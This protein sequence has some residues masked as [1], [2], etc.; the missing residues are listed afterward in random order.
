MDHDA[1]MPPKAARTLQALFTGG[2]HEQVV[3]VAHEA[4]RRG[5]AAELP[6]DLPAALREALLAAGVQSLHGHQAAARDL[7]AAGE[8][9]V[10]STGT[11]SGKSLCYQLAVLEAFAADPQ[12]RALFLFP[13]K[14]LAQDQA[15]KLNRF[16]VPGVVPAIY[17]GDTPQDQRPL[18]QAHR[19]DPAQQ[20][21]HA[22]R[23]HPARPRALGRVPAPAAV[24]RARRGARLPRRLRQPRRPGRAPPAAPLPRSTA[25]TRAFV[26]TSA[27]I[28]N[29]QALRRAAG[30]RAVRGRRRGPGAASRADGRPLEPAARGP[31]RRRAPERARRGELRDGRVRARRRARDRLR[32]DAQGGG[33][34]LRPRP[35][36]PRGPR[37]ARRGGPGAAVSRRLHAGAA[38]R[39][40]AAPV[41]PRARRRRGDAGARAGHRRRQPGRLAG[42]RLPGHD[43]QPAPAL[44]TGRPVRARLRRAG[45]RPG[46]ARP[47]LH[48]RA[49]PPPGAQR[50]GGDHRPAQPA[51]QRPAPGGGRVRAAA[52][53]RRRGLLRRGGPAAG[54]AA[55]AGRPAAAAQGRPRL[56]QALL[57]RRRASACARRATSSSPSSRPAR[58]RSSAPSSA[59]ASSASATP[60]PSTCTWA[61]AT[62]S[63]TS[64]SRRAPS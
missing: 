16:R 24:R 11:A 40:R 41:R 12:A 21:R 3:T 44:G 33:A 36:P 7:L 9:V 58:A 46:R 35:P 56:G 28:A 50:R 34:R 1:G 23:R 61:G 25:P 37:P 43:H 38:A 5:R 17:D 8:N 49:R 64:T 14:A 54:R 62:S 32:A 47:V 42:H 26:L 60:A 53:G 45:G 48:A 18:L 51:H 59:S 63:S 52:H 4:A 6:A 29:P 57:P 27:T 20:P 2:G 30:R 13:T 10:V 19:D 39:H 55:R 15:R 22:A 31:R